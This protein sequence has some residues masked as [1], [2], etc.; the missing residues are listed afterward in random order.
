MFIPNSTEFCKRV[1]NL[2][3]SI[4]V[5]K[6]HSLLGVHPILSVVCGT[7]DGHSVTGTL[8][9][10]RDNTESRNNLL[11]VVRYC[12]HSSI[13]P[14]KETVWAFNE[15]QSEIL[16]LESYLNKQ[17]DDIED[18][19]GLH[20]YTYPFIEVEEHYTDLPLRKTER[21]NP[22]PV[23][24]ISHI[25]QDTKEVSLEDD[26]FE[27]RTTPTLLVP[28]LALGSLYVLSKLAD[29]T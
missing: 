7:D 25:N 28:T 8:R 17:S 27:H 1:L 21:T 6:R 22:N 23:A 4:T 2:V 11:T 5:P 10:I 13:Y 3:R 12:V 20:S 26:S 18:V 24:S 29:D 16:A 14:H 19:V 9:C 15:P